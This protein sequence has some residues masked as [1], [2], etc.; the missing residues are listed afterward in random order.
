M[1]IHTRWIKIFKDMWANRSRSL[2]VILS[3]AVGVAAVGMINSAAY[4]IKRDLYGQHAAGNPAVLEIYVSPFDESLASSV[5]GMREVETAG[6]RRTAGALIYHS[7]ENWEDITLNVLPDYADIQVNRL[8]FEEGEAKPGSRG[9]LL[10]RGSAKGLGVSIG[11]TV[12]IETDDERRYALMVTGI[13]Q[14]NYV[15]PYNLM[16]EAGG[17]V[18][19]ETLEWMGYQPYFNRLEIITA[20]SKNDT[21]HIL[22]VGETIRDRVIE[23]AGYQVGSIQIPGIGADPGEHWAGKQINGFLL[24]LT[25]MGILA[26]LLSGGL[27]INT[28]S[29]IL[30]QQLR[31]I[32][33]MRSVGAT[34]NQIIT[35]YLLNVFI[36]SVLGLMI[37]YPLG[38]LG[39]YGLA[40]FAASMINFNLSAATLPVNV[41]LLQTALGLLMPIGVAL[42]PIFSGTKLSVYDAIYQDGRGSDK[43]SNII[44]NAVGWLNSFSPTIMLS[45]RNTFRKKGRLAFTLVT[46]TLAGAM[47]ISVFSTRSSLNS[48]IKSI[49]RYIVYDV[50]LSIPGGANKATVEREAMRIPDIEYAEGWASSRG[51]IIHNDGS[52]GEEMEVIGLPADS[53]TVD[54]LL[55]EG[56]W[57]QPGDTRQVVVNDDLL[58]EEP[59]IKI[60]SEIMLKVG[61]KERSYEV[62][63]IASKH[64]FMTRVYMVDEEYG[65]LTGLP[66]QVNMVR[67]RA[68]LDKISKT[69]VQK[70]L[71]LQL[72]ERFTNAQ[73]STEN[74][75]TREQFF[76]MFTDV[77][78]IILI[79]LVIMAA[80]L[81]IVGGLG[82]TG[83]IGMNVLERTREIGVLRAVGASNRSV[84][85]VVLVEGVSVALIAWVLGAFISGPSGLALA[86][87]VIKAVLSAEASYQYSVAG[88]FVWLAVVVLIGVISS[89]AP[90]ENAVQLTVREVLDYE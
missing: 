78:N 17:Y 8:V 32:G 56:R 79:V 48:Q 27:V 74:S 63:G 81:A 40:M 26:I 20:E 1:N 7:K 43:S 57:L 35:M 18:N 75:T 24:I 90:A 21:E 23:S 69:S 85:Q 28:V 83:T 54:P 2:L 9:I 36:F 3:I 64:I 66:N 12:T 39:G 25:I 55:L 67:V 6:A 71:A 29:A 22:A 34:R 47:F 11:D 50:S 76:S 72:E 16:H 37:A 49:S 13:I 73:L 80:I 52:E 53:K 59:N 10:E 61:D 58:V 42:V 60:G 15:V 41:F 62:V 46:L 84:R 70:D 33:I 14:D 19:M 68:D 87:A 44:E 82:L 86:G 38:L 77:F 65:R 51:V 45:L 4:M 88:L 5:E 31:Q 30:N 89:L